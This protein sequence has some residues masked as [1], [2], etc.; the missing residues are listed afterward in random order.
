M[1]VQHAWIEQVRCLARADERL[2]AALTYGSFTKG[3]GDGFSDIEFWLFVRD[4]ALAELDRV[5]WVGAVASPLAVLENLPHALT[6][7]IFEGY[8]RGEFHFAPA[9]RMGEVRSWAENGPFPSP[10]AMLLLDR[11]GELYGHLQYL[12]DHPPQHGGPREVQ[13]VLD[14]FINWSVQGA[15]VLRRGE[16]ARALGTLGVL[17]VHL[18]QL[19]RL[20][21]GTT[22]HWP[23]PSKGV[24]ADLSGGA[25]RRFSAC[26]ASVEPR[27]LERAYTQAWEWGKELAGTL[28][29]WMGRRWP[30]TFDVPFEAL[31]STL[32]VTTTVA[33]PGDGN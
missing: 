18:L 6:L 7:A 24:E 25:Y 20:V 3:E 29:G 16:Y 10:E 32:E 13:G 8:R 22:L 31:A 28:L 2:V 26:T 19:A 21:E 1:L 23:T 17:H 27:E 5:G 14:S 4:D 30:S 11:T 12:H 33:R 9:S 15:Q